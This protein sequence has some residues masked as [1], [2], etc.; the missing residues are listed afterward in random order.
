MGHTTSLKLTV[1]K[2]SSGTL[3]GK[4]KAKKSLPIDAITHHPDKQHREADDLI[5]Q[6]AHHVA[7]L[8]KTNQPSP[9][10]RVPK[11]MA[12]FNIRP[13]WGGLSK[14]RMERSK[15]Y[16]VMTAK[17]MAA[18]HDPNRSGSVSSQ[19]KGMHSSGAN[20]VA[21]VLDLE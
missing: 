7:G 5:E 19:Y 10:I 3:S 11:P 6:I 4:T 16:R 2:M 17:V 21:M 15:A 18:S 8:N 14:A 13:S 9:H 20:T 1:M 12:R